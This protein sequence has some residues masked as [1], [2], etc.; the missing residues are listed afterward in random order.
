VEYRH[1]EF[2]LGTQDEITNDGATGTAPHVEINYGAAPNVQLHLIVPVGYSW[3]SGGPT[4]YGLGDVEVGA[5]F[6][7]VQESEGK[8]IPMVG[9]FPL[10]ELPVGNESK[11]LGAGH[12]RAF[13]PVWFQKSFGPWTSYGGGGYWLNPGAG[14]HNFWFVGWQVQRR[15]S[16]HVTLGTEVFHTTADSIHASSNQGFNVGLVLD[17]SEKQHVL[18]SAGR[19]TAGHGEYQGYLAYQLTF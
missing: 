2:Y 3:P 16:H 11:G 9:T 15:F 8:K 4:M 13:I 12:V 6:R 7:F 10:L 17:L 1:W 14:N 5:K 19:A 18:F